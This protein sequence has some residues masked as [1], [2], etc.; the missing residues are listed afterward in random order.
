MVWEETEGG[1]RNEKECKRLMKKE[2]ETERAGLRG[3][4]RRE[5]RMEVRRRTCRITEGLTE[6]RRE[7]TAGSEGRASE[8][9]RL[10]MGRL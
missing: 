1:S 5:Q 7:A 9:S 6:E 10:L 4:C 3:L 8:E 2:E